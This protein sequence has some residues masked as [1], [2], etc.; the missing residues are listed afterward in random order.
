MQ[1]S[2]VSRATHSKTYINNAIDKA[3]IQHLTDITLP[4][5]ANVSFFGIF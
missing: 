5:L 1:L 2:G 3:D 4:D